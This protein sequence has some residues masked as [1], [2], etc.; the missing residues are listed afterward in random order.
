MILALDIGNTNIKAGYFLKNE[1]NDFVIFR[2]PD[3]LFDSLIHHEFNSAAISSVVPAL[4]A[5][6]KHFLEE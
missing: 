4:T 3:E 2:N 6:V 1:L 5:R